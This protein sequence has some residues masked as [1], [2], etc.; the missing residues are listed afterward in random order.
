[1]KLHARRATAGFSS[2]AQHAVAVA[3]LL[4]LL[5][6]ASDLAT[7]LFLLSVSCVHMSPQIDEEEESAELSSDQVVFSVEDAARLGWSLDSPLTVGKV[8][9]LVAMQVKV[10]GSELRRMTRAG[11]KIRNFTEQELSMAKEVAALSRWDFKQFA[12]SGDVGFLLEQARLRQQATPW[13]VA[14]DAMV[15]NVYPDGAC[16]AFTL[17]PRGVKLLPVLT[18]RLTSMSQ[19][20]APVG[21]S[22][23][24][25]L[26]LVGIGPMTHMAGGPRFLLSFHLVAMTEKSLHAF[27]TCFKEQERQHFHS[28]MPFR[29]DSYGILAIYPL[30]A[31]DD[32]RDLQFLQE[33]ARTFEACYRKSSNKCLPHHWSQS[34]VR[35]T[36]PNHADRTLRQDYM[37][38]I[39]YAPFHKDNPEIMLSVSPTCF[40][41]S[42]CTDAWVTSSVETNKEAAVVMANKPPAEVHPIRIHQDL[43]GQ[44]LMGPGST[45]RTAVAN[46]IGLLLYHPNHETPTDITDQNSYAWLQELCARFDQPQLAIKFPS[47]P[48]VTQ[49]IR[50]EPAGLAQASLQKQLQM[51]ASR[52]W[53]LGGVAVCSQ[54]S[55]ADAQ[56]DILTHLFASELFAQHVRAMVRLPSVS[57]VCILLHPS[58]PAPAEVPPISISSYVIPSTWLVP[59]GLR[60]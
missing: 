54:E 15:R 8:Q 38:G 10:K 4:P 13:E 25:P 30:R 40:L 11:S 60:S 57:V 34:I 37:S 45:Q 28:S 51:L 2:I 27:Y 43:V 9:E 21:A 26:Y 32:Q 55:N 20:C 17:L 1:M 46:Q 48:H 36:S 29:K 53:L 12:R 6:A 22:S 59:A 33:L 18:S 24:D 42:F 39:S 31:C 41:P 47:T 49:L 14:S 56:L 35:F 58:T 7:Q 23:K 44:L 5:A 52:G 16:G 3:A 19:I 50:M